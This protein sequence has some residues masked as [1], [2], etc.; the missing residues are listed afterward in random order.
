MS[1]L[2]FFKK[3][4]R[5]RWFICHNC[6]MH[7]DHD[8][9]NSIFYSESPMVNILGR[10]TMICPRCNDGNT[11]SFQEIK[12]EG[13]ESTLWGLERIVRKH[14]KSR[15]IVKPANSQTTAVSQNQPL[16]Q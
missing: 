9:L 14:P 5:T 10:P 7:N 1:I 4:D 3:I 2:N 12:D 6:L 11:R 8:T 16:V 15:F 13:S